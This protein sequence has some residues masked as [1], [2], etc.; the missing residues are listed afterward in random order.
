MLGPRIKEYMTN[1]GL[2]FGRIAE[3][4]GIPFNVFSAMING[5][6]KITAEEYFLICNALSVPLE[7]FYD[8]SA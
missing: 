2:K 4:A 1:H 7:Q 3:R 8:A 5:K 6:R